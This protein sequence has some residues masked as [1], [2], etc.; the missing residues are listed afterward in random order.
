MLLLGGLCMLLLSQ[1][2]WSDFVR[3]LLKRRSCLFHEMARL[4]AP[5]VALLVAV[6]AWPSFA[7]A[8]AQQPPAGALKP[9]GGLYHISSTGGRNACASPDGK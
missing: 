3:L 5:L 7:M 9:V 1:G 6:H 2:C 8:S 4:Q